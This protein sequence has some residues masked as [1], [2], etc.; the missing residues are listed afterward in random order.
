MLLKVSVGDVAS[1]VGGVG[2]S[3][4]M[5]AVEMAG[6][7]VVMLLSALNMDARR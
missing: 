5:E 3:K 2:I 4:G 1:V 7:G 6:W